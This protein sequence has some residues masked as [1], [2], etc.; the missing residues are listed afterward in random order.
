MKNKTRSDRKSSNF[1]LIV[2]QKSYPTSRPFA[3]QNYKVYRILSSS[4]YTVYA[5]GYIEQWGKTNY[6][7]SGTI[8]F[9]I[10]ISN[11]T[12][13]YISLTCLDDVT[14]NNTSNWAIYNITDKSFSFKDNGYYGT[15]NGKL[16]KVTGY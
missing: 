9:L 7:T 6:Q 4:N 16:W 10:P 13:C 3:T 11:P 2:I 1:F 12:N 8:N 15:R 5:S 14:D